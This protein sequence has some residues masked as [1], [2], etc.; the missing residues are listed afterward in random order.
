MPT[1]SERFE[2]LK[3]RSEKALVLFLTAG[4]QP[5]SELPSI[6][7]ALEEGGADVIEIGI[8]FS[9]PFGEGP[10]IQASSQRALDNGVTPRKILETLSQIKASVPIV[11]MGYYNPILRF[12]LN[13]FAN[14]SRDAGVT[15]TIISDLVPDEA[16][17]WCAA[18][19][20]AG[21]DTIFLVAPTS[22][23]ERIN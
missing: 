17:D 11:T 21:I 20:S 22:T 8:P 12:G 14:K 3:L 23:P 6:V 2:I 5:L 4:D 16:E 1:L 7:A 19:A 18:S 13:E 15:G 10:T 9:D